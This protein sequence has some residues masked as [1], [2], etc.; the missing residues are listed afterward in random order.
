VC[1][2]T[3]LKEKREIYQ[4][5]YLYIATRISEN[6]LLNLKKLTVILTASIV[7]MLILGTKLEVLLPSCLLFL[8]H[9]I[10]YAFIS[11]WFSRTIIKDESRKRGFRDVAFVLPRYDSNNECMLFA[12]DTG[13]C[14]RLI[15]ERKR[16]EEGRREFY[17][18]SHLRERALNNE[19]ATNAYARVQSLSRTFMTRLEVC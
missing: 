1:V 11:E 9:L 13:H 3:R 17:G 7:P 16:E 2:R 4:F 12:P 6:A 5:N 10:H 19:R 8:I 18:L 14:A 15:R